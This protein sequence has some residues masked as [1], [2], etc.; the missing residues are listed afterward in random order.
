MR[1]QATD[2]PGAVRLRTRLLSVL[3]L[4]AV[5][6]VAAYLLIGDGPATSDHPPDEVEVLSAET[7]TQTQPTGRWRA[8]V[9]G[10]SSL[11]RSGAHAPLDYRQ[12]PTTW[13]FASESCSSDGCTGTVSSSS[14]LSFP[15]HWDGRELVVDRRLTDT[16][17]KVACSDGSG[18]AVPIAEGT[19]AHTYRYRFGSF[20]GTANRLTSRLVIE[21]STEFSGSCQALPDDALTYVEDQVLTKLPEG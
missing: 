17:G 13:T 1:S 9:I 12:Q 15:Y 10:R 6:A 21:I 2:D 18:A 16:S 19:A 11:L 5:G 7:I 14:G 4:V 3:G 20:A 8:Q